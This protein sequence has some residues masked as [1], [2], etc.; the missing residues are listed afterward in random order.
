[1]CETHTIQTYA[2]SYQYDP[3][4][5]TVLRNTFAADMARRFKELITVITK[6]VVERD[7]FG[8]S[9]NQMI[10]PLPNAFDFP[11]SV[12]KVEAF[13][14][15]LQQQ[16]D[17]GILE[18]GSFP[19]GNVSRYAWTNKYILDSYK[20]GLLRARS[21]LK[22]AGYDVTPMNIDSL[23]G[24][25]FHMDR[26]GLLF[27]RAFEE[28]KGVTNDMSKQISKILSQGMVDGDGPILMAKKL[29]SV[30]DGI[31]SVDLGVTDTLGRFI[32]AKR[33]AEM[34]ARTEVIRAHHQ[35][36]INEYKSWGAAGVNVQ[37]EFRTAGDNRVCSECLSLEGETFDLETAMYIIPVHPM[38]RCIC[39]PIKMK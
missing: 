32:P 34:I 22:K 2:T 11:L 33:R 3:T 12:D 20:R 9:T 38:C 5:T 36:T 18:V 15:W 29:K 26:V 10:S 8:L 31:S 25:P 30:I 6:T 39:L 35:A 27:I 14:E 1:M 4:R 16:I 28:L 17:A 19:T 21:E 7:A 13:M 24:T 23:M 37:A